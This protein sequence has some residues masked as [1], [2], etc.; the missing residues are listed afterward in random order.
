[1]KEPLAI[2]VGTNSQGWAGPQILKAP[3]Q[4]VLTSGPGDTW[5]ILAN[6][7]GGGGGDG[8]GTQDRAGKP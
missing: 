5:A 1:M 2:R 4:T 3:S 8:E 7:S 6:L